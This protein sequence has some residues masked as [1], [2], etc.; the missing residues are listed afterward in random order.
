VVA[1]MLEANPALTPTEIKRI[2]QQT[3][4]P[5][6]RRDR[7][8][9]GAGRLDA[10]SALARVKDAARPFG[11][12]L[13]GWLDARPYRI[14]H[15]PA[16][17]TTA[18]LPAG[19]AVNIPVHLSE[20]VLSWGMTL[21]WGT[22][23]GGNDL[24]VRVADATNRELG[25][26][27][28]I[29]GTS[30][31]GRTEGLLLLGT[32]P[33]SMGVEVYFKTGSGLVDQPFQMRQE[34]AVAVVTAYGDVAALPAPDRDLVTRAVSRHV[35]VGRNDRFDPY[36][37]LTRE[38]LA[39]AL[40]LT[41]ELPQRIPANN[42]F[43]DVGTGDVSFPYVETVAGIRAR[44]VLMTPPNGRSFKPRD[45]VTRLDFT[46]AV[47]RAAGLEGLARMR[48]GEILGLKDEADIPSDLRGYV[49]VALEKGL[50]GATFLPDGTYFIPRGS[51]NR[52]DASRY[53][54]AL[55]DVRSGSD[56]TP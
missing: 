24:D 55:L 17:L 9:V 16:T 31:F 23:P 29:N 22:L 46:V 47:V 45:D 51:L 19:S 42:S 35:L 10:W 37:G 8:E 41:G 44:Q 54:L 50:I 11:T 20:P 28:S 52:L 14:E 4:T 1:L 53:L 15:R 39:R 40:A 30:L 38:E 25:R 48:S 18:L 33:S 6:L 3:A 36:D 49:A 32:V 26:S 43:P 21:A 34:T 2:L 12:Y 13:P 5:I 7:S 27:D 56:P